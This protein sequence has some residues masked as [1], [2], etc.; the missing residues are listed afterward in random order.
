MGLWFQGIPYAAC[1]DQ[2][3]AGYTMAHFVSKHSNHPFW[4]CSLSA[5]PLPLTTHAYGMVRMAL[6]SVLLELIWSA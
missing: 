5:K 4:Q 6:W 3:L 2:S 1:S